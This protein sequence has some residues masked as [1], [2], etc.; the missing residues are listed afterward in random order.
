[1]PLSADTPSALD[2]RLLAPRHWG[3]W[4]ALGLLW[5]LSFLPRRLLGLL[6]A[7]LARL[8]PWLNRKRWHIAQTNLA[9]CYPGLDAARRRTLLRRH[10]H[11]LVFCLLDLGTLWLRSSSRLARLGRIENP[12]MLEPLLAE[13]RGLI[14]MTPHTPALDHGAQLLAARYAESHP[15]VTMYKPQSD[16]VLDWAMQR[17]RRRHGVELVAREQGLRPVIRAMRRGSRIF[18][19]LPDEDHGE[20]HSVFAPFCCVPKATLPALGRLASLTGAPVLPCLA[21]VDPWRGRY[22][23]RFSAP[24]PDFPA[25]DPV[26]DATRMNQAIEALIAPDPAQYMWV[27]KL[28][29]T[30]P[31]GEADPYSKA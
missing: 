9:L 12:Q 17:R 30:R 10:F 21:V 4:L 13:G 16:P 2:R 6:A 3:S 1:M 11:V 24:L 7:G 23:V 5:L 28:F 20:R 15:V 26:A 8:A 25:A 27:Y 31:P 19:Y 18:F 22:R 14:L 29:R